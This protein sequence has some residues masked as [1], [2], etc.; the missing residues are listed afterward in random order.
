MDHSSAISV[1]NEIQSRPFRVSHNP[2]KVSQNCLVKG[3][4]LI[5][6]LGLMGYTVRGRIGESYWDPAIYPKEILHLLPNSILTTHFY[7]EIFL[8]DKWR[9]LDTSFQPTLGKCGLPIG[10]W[11][12]DIVCFP[13]TKLYTQEES[14]AYQAK[15]TDKAYL[16]NFFDQGKDFWIALDKWFENK[17]EE[18]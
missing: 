18:R 6:S 3:L 9:K 14:L 17:A 16:K 5:K 10:S 1:F 7:V 8:N 12:N 15:W 11:E 4:D 13:I 2:D